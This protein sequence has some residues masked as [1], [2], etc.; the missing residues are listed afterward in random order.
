MTANVTY[1]S[2][3]AANRE[4]DRLFPLLD[5]CDITSDQQQDEDE[6][7]TVLRPRFY[8]N[9]DTIE[10][11]KRSTL[12]GAY[13][14]AVGRSLNSLPL[15]HTSTVDALRVGRTPK[16]PSVE[17]MMRGSLS[18]ICASRNVSHDFGPETNALVSLAFALRLLPDVPSGQCGFDTRA[19]T[20]KD[21]FVSYVKRVCA[22]FAPRDD[23]DAWAAFPGVPK[24][25][26]TAVRKPRFPDGAHWSAIKSRDRSAIFGTG[27]HLGLV[28]MLALRTTQPGNVVARGLAGLLLCMD[29]TS[30]SLLWL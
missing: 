24:M 28:A 23:D 25:S 17:N 3:E 8:V 16:D 22:A 12:Y 7:I 4:V 18:T 5:G 30:T 10:T 6:D 20:R 27:L 1:Q 13:V 2:M 15:R 26:S 19:C 21:V 29:K 14:I 11:I 9:R